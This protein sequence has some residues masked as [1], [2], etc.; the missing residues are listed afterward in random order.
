MKRLIALIVLA[1]YFSSFSSASTL[2]N[3]NSLLNEIN[4]IYDAARQLGYENITI[5]LARPIAKLNPLNVCPNSDHLQSINNAI[6]LTLTKY[7]T[8]AENLNEQF[9]INIIIIDYK[10]VKGLMSKVNMKNITAINVACGLINDF[11]ELILAAR[12][13]TENPSNYTYSLFYRNLIKIGI[14]LLLLE[15]DPTLKMAYKVAGHQLTEKQLFDLILD[16]GGSKSLKVAAS[17]IYWELK[18]KI[19]EIIEQ[20]TQYEEAIEDI[21]NLV[22]KYQTYNNP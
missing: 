16:I 9:K 7:R 22:Q 20:R 18:D 1:L 6:N 11:N 10:S 3:Q 13:V 17:L 5:S 14:D 12:Q 19:H 21:I 15:A 8:T 4:S 2:K